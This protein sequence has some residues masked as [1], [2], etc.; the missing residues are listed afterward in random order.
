VDKLKKL[1][2]LLFKE[3]TLQ[4]IY[5]Q[6]RICLRRENEFYS[7]FDDVELHGKRIFIENSIACKQ[8]QKK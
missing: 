1:Q 3:M 6:N 7:G 2:D 5:M 8:Y 4:D